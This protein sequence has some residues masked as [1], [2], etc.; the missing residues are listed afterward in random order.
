MFE[1]RE[2]DDIKVGDKVRLTRTIS[3]AEQALYSASIGGF[4]PVHIDDGYA[5]TTRF[6]ERIGS[7]IMLAGMC[8]SILTSHLVGIVPV[9]IEDR[10]RFTGA[11][12][13]G[14][15][16]TIEVSVTAKDPERRSIEWKGRAT[17]QDG[18]EVLQAEATMK[19]PRKRP[20]A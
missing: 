3:E 18:V 15:T 20:A 8:T 9:S 10:F 5:R 2:Y 13:F 14:D 11:V 7:G 6:G 17:N 19:Y 1:V 16:I 12:R 4:G